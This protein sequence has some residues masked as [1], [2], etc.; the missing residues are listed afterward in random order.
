MLFFWVGMWPDITDH[1]LVTG[2]VGDVEERVQ[3]LC[4][5]MSQSDGS[6]RRSDLASSCSTDTES[7]APGAERGYVA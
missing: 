3:Q 6:T 5:D 4:W 2:L 1:V 7:R